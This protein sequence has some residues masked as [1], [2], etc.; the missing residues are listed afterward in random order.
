MN[1]I[2]I[3][4][5]NHYNHGTTS[6][7][8]CW[9]IVRQDGAVFTFTSTDRDLVIDGLTYEAATGFTPSAIVGN[10]N[11]AVDN[12]EVVGVLNSAS[13]TEADLIAGL[14]DFSRIEIFEV[15]HRDLSMGMRKMASGT[16][17]EVS[18]GRSQ[19]VAELRGLA[20]QAQ[21]VVGS[22]YSKTCRAELFSATGQWRCNLN[23]ADYLVSG[24]ITSAADRRNFT[25]NAR[26]EAADWFKHGK[27]TFASGDN[28]GLSME[29]KNYASGAFELYMPMPH[30][31]IPGDTYT[32][33]PG[34]NKIGKDG[35]CKNKFNNM[36]HFS[37]EENVP[38]ND[39]LMKVGGV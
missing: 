7:A 25:D 37:G 12:L 11:M 10:S 6:L 14:W 8:T 2:P 13:I 21:Q 36:I 19:F 4:L 16:I 1:I 26:G 30:E 17:G 23:E 18:I 20:Q 32:A 39:A 29:I 38:G 34:C 35:D 22:L 28:A 31:V 15:N 3:Q 24:T 33:T 27:I 5:A 9:K